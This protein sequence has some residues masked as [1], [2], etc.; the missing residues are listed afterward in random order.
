MDI[1]KTLK[2][3]ENELVES[4]E[5]TRRDRMIHF[6]IKLAPYGASSIVG[7]PK[8]ISFSIVDEKGV[9]DA[10]DRIHEGLHTLI[11]ESKITLK[12]LKEAD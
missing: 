9:N 5:S 7:E 8:E 1:V 2:S 10:L 4:V 6:T 12:N 3:L 11:R